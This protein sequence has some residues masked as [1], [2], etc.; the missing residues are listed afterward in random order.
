MTPTQ[1]KPQLRWGIIATGWI[2]SM[3][4]QDLLAPRA[5]A[6]ARHIVSSIGS[7]SVEKAN[8]FI[9]KMWK[10]SAEPRPSPYG[11]YQEVYNDP[12]VD[13]VYIGTPHVLH[14]QNCLDAIA[15]GKNVL[16]EKPFAMN[17]REAQEIV[18]AAKNRGV[19][20][21]EAMWTKFFPVVQALYDH[22][23]VKKSIGQVRRAFVDFG[24]SM[25]FDA[26]PGDSRLKD[27]KLGAG[28][29][30]DI[31]I[32]TL[33]YASII[34]GEGKLGDE[35]PH[36]KISSSME[37][38][39]GVDESDSVILTYDAGAARRLPEGSITVFSDIGPS[40]PKGFRVTREGEEPVVYRFDSPEG[41]LGF[42]YEAD[43]VAC[44]IAQGKLENDVMPLSE[45]L[46]MMRLI[47]E[48]R[49][50]NGHKYPQDDA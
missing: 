14:K 10:A 6:P 31:G 27:P 38:I 39:N 41:T 12:N 17:E 43:A 37:I 23:Y 30:L 49:R 9:D 4:V 29:I 46:R 22:I 21:M 5:D 35:H 32:Y 44:D 19:F 25:D 18:D 50:Q 47:D 2:S 28:A 15:A 8:A 1:E 45:T 3:F 34:M 24:S 13:I 11:T 7:S 36:P 42:F 26:I 20:I 48:C 33:T 16:C 40:C